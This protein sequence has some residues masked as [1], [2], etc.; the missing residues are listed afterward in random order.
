MDRAVVKSG[1]SIIAP[2][3]A[4]NMAKQ[5]VAIIGAGPF[6]LATAAH[7]AAAGIEP[8]VFGEPMKFWDSRMPKGMLLRSAWYASSISDPARTLGLDAYEQ[9]HGVRISVPI[10][11]QHFLDYGMWFQGQSV[12]NLQ[13][14]RVMRVEPNGAGFCLFLEGNEQCHAHRV[15]VA[16]GIEPFAYIPPVFDSVKFSEHLVTHSSQHR[17]FSR[18]AGQDVIV[19]GAGQ[20]A[21]E[22]AALLSEAGAQVEIV[23]R[24]PRINWLTGKARLY[25]DLSGAD[26]LLRTRADV[27]PPILTH[28]VSRPALLNPFPRGLRNWMVLR[29]IRPAGAQWLR[30]RLRKVRISTGRKIVTAEKLD[31]RIKLALSD[32]SHRTIDHVILASGY[33]VDISR[34][35]FLAPELVAAIRC[36]QGYPI[37][38]LGLESSVPGL[39]FVGASSAWSYGPLMRFVSGTE[40]SS[41]AVTGHILGGSR[42]G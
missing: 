29:A 32:G 38:G 15:I 13:R 6:G 3:I 7:L 40:Y 42:I 39:H 20:S 25:R 24:K 9:A 34:Y 2:A 10:P 26:R 16:A 19:I 21:L 31:R 4:S 41:R 1:G 18:F 14:R 28:I 27:G 37:L 22:G 36:M 33:R 23:A 35:D 30:P 12:P 17:D 8:I 11:L 5:R